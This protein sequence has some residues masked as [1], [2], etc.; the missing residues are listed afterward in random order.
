MGA[1][2][3]IATLRVKNGTYKK[4][5]EEKNRYQE[6]GVLLSSPHGSQLIISLHATASSEQKYV[7]VT[8][9]PGVKISLEETKEE[10]PADDVAPSADEVPF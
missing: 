5:G 10:A 2:H 3:K 9:D 1:F 6:V 7:Y 8:N 4:D